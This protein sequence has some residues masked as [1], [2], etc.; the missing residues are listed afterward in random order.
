MDFFLIS[1]NFTDVLALQHEVARLQ[2]TKGGRLTS[3]NNKDNNLSL[4]ALLQ[5]QQRPSLLTSC[6]ALF[7]STLA[8]SSGKNRH[9]TLLINRFIINIYLTF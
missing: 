7:C 9:Y 2:F 4:L 3:A 6:Q 1:A 5:V 8:P